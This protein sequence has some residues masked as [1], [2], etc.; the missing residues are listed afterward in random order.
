[1]KINSQK[2]LKIV[3]FKNIFNVKSWNNKIESIGMKCLKE[4]YYDIKT[5]QNIFLK[6]KSNKK[7][8]HFPEYH[9]SFFIK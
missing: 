3:C 9:I 1:M 4:G 2:K 8:E 5:K 6:A 7:R